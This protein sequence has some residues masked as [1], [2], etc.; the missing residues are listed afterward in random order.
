MLTLDLSTHALPIRSQRN[1]SIRTH[2]Q[3]HVAKLEANRVSRGSGDPRTQNEINN[4][5]AAATYNDGD[6]PS[7]LFSNREERCQ[8]SSNGKQSSTMLIQSG[9]SCSQMEKIGAEVEE[10]QMTLK[11]SRLKKDSNISGYGWAS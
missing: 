10:R 8:Q 2:H 5:A 1:S 3:I 4:S 11:N 7:S 6:I 9:R